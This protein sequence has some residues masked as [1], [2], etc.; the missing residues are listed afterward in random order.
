[1]NLTSRLKEVFPS[2]SE[3]EKFGK[4]P[5]R[6]F[7]FNLCYTTRMKRSEVRVQRGKRLKGAQSMPQ[8]LAFYNRLKH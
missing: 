5:A 1:L 3:M 8:E 6:D 7:P 2:Q 4:I